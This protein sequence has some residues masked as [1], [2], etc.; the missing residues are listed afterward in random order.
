MPKKQKPSKPATP[1]PSRPAQP[2]ARPPVNRTPIMP[3]RP[4]RQPGR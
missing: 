1:P 2:P 3:R 4:I